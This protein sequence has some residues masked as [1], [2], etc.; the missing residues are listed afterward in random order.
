MS[1]F[2]FSITCDAAGFKGAQSYS[3]TDEE[4]QRLMWCFDHSY[5]CGGN[6]KK[7]FAAMAEWISVKLIGH[8]HGY[9][10]HTPPNP[11]VP[12]PE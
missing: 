7:M 8:V 2:S 5:A 10:L 9:E 6:E 4:M 11:I 12:K 3:I 1:G